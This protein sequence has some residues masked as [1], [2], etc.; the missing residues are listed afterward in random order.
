M[1]NSE[2]LLKVLGGDPNAYATNYG[3]RKAIL[4]ALG[5]N[6][7]SCSN[8]NEVD[9][10]I[11]RIYESGGGG[12]SGTVV[13]ETANITKNGTYVPSEGYNGFDKAIV[14]VLPVL[15]TANIT[16][17]GTYVPS[18]GF[19]GFSQATVNVIP[20]VETINITKNGTYTPSSGYDGFG[21][22]VVKVEGSGG[23][24]DVIYVK[25]LDEMSFAFNSMSSLPDKYVFSGRVNFENMFR[26]CNKL[27]TIPLI[28]TSDGTVFS[29]MFQSCS[30][31]TTIPLIDT[32]NGINFD[33]MFMEC[34]KLTAIPQL[35]TSNG[36]SFYNM[37]YN[38]MNLTT[39][40]QLNTS[41]GTNFN[42]M[43]R[44]CFL[45]T[46]IPPLNTSNGTNFCDMFNEC[47]ALITAPQMDTS[48][49]TNFE[50]MYDYCL[51][52]TELPAELNT[53][54]G[55]NFKSMFN[56][57]LKL[58]S[59]PALDFRKN[60][61][62]TLYPLRRVFYKCSSLVSI[63]QINMTGVK[64]DTPNAFDYCESLENIVFVG[65]IDTSIDFS[66]STKLT[67]DSVK[68]ILTACSNTT[69]TTS[70]TLKFKVTHTD[71]D[72]EL[73]ALI[74]TCNTKGWTISGLTLN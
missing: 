30:S 11:L 66:Y 70:K 31:L 8:I 23:G 26:D 46:T 69:T 33:Q 67:Y 13:L 19:D 47:K 56:E 14:N 68:S 53:S 16:K 29:N 6:P 20:T 7:E 42:S 65:S 37:F 73:A 34:R 50:K 63:Q 15:E 24:S 5:G 36:T 64:V 41:N 38:C 61:T 40:Q 39:V 58:T 74:A 59:I 21:T 60:S 18:S 43:F 45:L 17:N 49:G 52:L 71:V 10:E 25:D 3:V 1:T 22:V 27:T 57:C 72:G 62:S 54:K 28:D 55:T 48:N 9:L 44:K 2:K 12:T 32:S 51:E 35:D 4:S